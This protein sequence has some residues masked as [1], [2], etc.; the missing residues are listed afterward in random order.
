[1]A[2]RFT[3][4]LIAAIAASALINTAEAALPT[5]QTQAP[6]KAEAATVFTY[7]GIKYAVLSEADKTC[8]TNPASP[9]RGNNVTGDIVIP[10]KVMNGDV[11]YSVV[12]VGKGSFY[13]NSKLTGIQ[14]PEG[15]MAIDGSAF[16]GCTAL[17][18]ANLPSTLSSL[19]SLA[20]RQCRLD[21]V[22]IPAALTIIGINPFA[23]N[24][25]LTKLTVS[26]QNPNF[27]FA[28]NIL[29]TKGTDGNFSHVVACLMSAEGDFTVPYAV[30]T[31]GAY[32]FYKCDKL[33]SLTLPEGLT[34]IGEY[35]LGALT[36]INSLTLP[37]SVTEV[38]ANAIRACSALESI[39]LSSGM[40][41]IPDYMLEECKKLSSLV[42]PSGITSIGKRAFNHCV[43]IKSIELPNTLTKISEEAFYYCDSLLRLDIP[44]SV[45]EIGP[46]ALCQCKSLTT[47]NIP[48]GITSIP[49]GLFCGCI[50][51]ESFDVPEWV[52]EI[53][54]SAFASS[55][56][57][58]I[59]FHD[60]ITSI[61]EG[62]F[63]SCK[64]LEEF[65]MPDQIISIGKRAFAYCSALKSVQFSKS[66]TSIGENAFSE[67]DS[68]QR[69]DLP[70]G[71]TTISKSAFSLCSGATYLYIPNTVTS[72]GETAFQK[73]KSLPEIIIPLSVE[74]L[75]KKAFYSCEGLTDIYVFNHKPLSIDGAMF[76]CDTW[77]TT[78]TQTHV[79][80][81]ATLHVPEGSLDAYKAA[82][83]WKS[84]KS[85][86][87]FQTIELSEL[88]EAVYGEAP[89]NLASYLPEVLDVA[90]V[91]SDPETAEVN[92]K[93]LLI[94][95][96]GQVRISITRGSTLSKDILPSASSRTL[97]IAKAD[98]TVT[99]RSYTIN[100]G[101]AMPQFELDY[102]GFVNGDTSADLDE[103]PTVS[104]AASDSSTDG[105]FAIEITGGSDSNYNLITRNGELT[106]TQYDGIDAVGLNGISVT[107][108]EG[109]IIVSGLAQGTVIELYDLAGRLAACVIA[110]DGST[111]LSAASG[112]YVLSA[113]RQMRKIV[114]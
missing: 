17:K 36:K 26:K 78:V 57:K 71:L 59:K 25:T 50:S 87:T 20:F 102:E 69:I 86:G 76:D 13:G 5:Q 103:K 58:S 22:G 27:S 19:G 97:S 74:S 46:Y 56:I 91:S 23:D 96:A 105:T 53:G 104:C 92:G 14:L 64:K 66:L 94:K 1:M 28:D 68:L 51:L 112:V 10:A 29:Y 83:G 8:Q 73:C 7:G 62:V 85:I 31:L 65:T 52:T 38:G 18:S 33:T 11:E 3:H 114:M 45:T 110:A 82:Y 106:I 67:C 100:Q 41:S 108:S 24:P 40:K 63:T 6:A 99:A 21:S 93:L 84:F 72:I 95:N 37:D 107:T 16:E 54:T 70:D 109:Q 39:K 34:S 90:F 60:G 43:S 4:L 79:Y 30:K 32:S 77:N 75:G 80:D 61:G 48:T 81:N 35:A 55:S 15:L 98:L 47:T 49:K 9:I 111:R 42:I 89:I 101:D 88:P 12:A 113:A 2:K 44:N